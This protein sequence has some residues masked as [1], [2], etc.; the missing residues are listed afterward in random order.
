MSRWSTGE[1]VKS[2]WF[3]PEELDATGVSVRL[4]PKRS[5]LRSVV[6]RA[7]NKFTTATSDTLRLFNG[8]STDPDVAFPALYEASGGSNTSE[9]VFSNLIPYVHTIGGNGIVFE[10]GVWYVISATPRDSSNSPF[11]SVT[12]FYT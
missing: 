11:D 9:F 2:V 6:L 8:G 4:I 5:R 7:G 10:D 3:D 12:L 1:Y